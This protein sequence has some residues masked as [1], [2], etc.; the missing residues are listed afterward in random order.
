MSDCVILC[1][2]PARTFEV[3]VSHQFVLL[4]LTSRCRRVVHYTMSEE[5]KH[6]LSGFV[7]ARVVKQSHIGSLHISIA[8]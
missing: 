1:A 4:M 7:V 2:C 3:I 8:W 6:V 5:S